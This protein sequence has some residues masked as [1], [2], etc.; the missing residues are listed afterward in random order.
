[1]TYIW[2]WNT[3][4][5]GPL[6]RYVKLRMRMRR[7]CLERFPRHRSL[8]IPTCIMAVRDARAVMHAAIAN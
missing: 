2:F 1:M 3:L 8:A 7:E 6:E 4:P 5:N